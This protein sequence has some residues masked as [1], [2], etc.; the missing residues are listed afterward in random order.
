MLGGQEQVS[1]GLN[2]YDANSMYPSILLNA[3]TLLMKVRTCRYD[4]I[5]DLESILCEFEKETTY[6][7]FI[8][9]NMQGT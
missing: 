4:S 6:N 3:S 9:L 8:S 2:S 1:P 7:L 5:V